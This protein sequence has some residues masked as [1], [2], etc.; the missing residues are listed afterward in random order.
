MRG[1]CSIKSSAHIIRLP[2]RKVL[3]LNPLIPVSD[4]SFRIL[5]TWDRVKSTRSFRFLLPR[6]T[7]SIPQTPEF[8]LY[9]QTKQNFGG[10]RRLCEKIRRFWHFFG[11][12]FNFF[13]RGNSADTPI[14]I[15]QPPVLSHTDTYIGLTLPYRTHGTVCSIAY[16]VPFPEIPDLSALSR[17]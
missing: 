3:G 7:D 2:V 13:C 17:H 9:R 5:L 12:F 11:R 8:K 15:P 6:Y 1:P 4:F 10:T 14:A 16:S